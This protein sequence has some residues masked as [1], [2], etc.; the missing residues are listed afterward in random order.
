MK[1]AISLDRDAFTT[2]KDFAAASKKTPR[3]VLSELVR[4]NLRPK[5]KLVRRNGFLLIPKIKGSK[6]V[7]MELINRLRDEAP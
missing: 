4:K 5:A 7:T 6:P 2:V 1:T 3:Q